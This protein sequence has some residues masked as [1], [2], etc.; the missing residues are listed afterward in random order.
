MILGHNYQDAHNG[1]GTGYY[2]VTELGSKDRGDQIVI[3]HNPQGN[4]CIIEIN[5]LV[6]ARAPYYIVNEKVTNSS[7]IPGLCGWINNYSMADY[8]HE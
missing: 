1:I 4:D 2:P 7:T 5:P 8:A 6:L 3:L